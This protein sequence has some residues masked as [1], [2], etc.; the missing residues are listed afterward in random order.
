MSSFDMIFPSR[1]TSSHVVML[2]DDERVCYLV[3]RSGV[4]LYQQKVT[5]ELCEL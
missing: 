5:D 4:T 2:P 1:P 3:F